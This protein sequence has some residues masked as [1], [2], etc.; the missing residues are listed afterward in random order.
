MRESCIKVVS[1]FVEL[2]NHPSIGVSPSALFLSRRIRTRL[3]LLHP[4]I[5]KTVHEKQA[6]QQKYHVAHCKAIFF[7]VGQSAWAR[8]Y[9]GREKW[10]YGRV[11]E[12]T[13]SIFHRLEMANGMV[14]RRHAD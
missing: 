1:V 6:Q 12:R 14:W 8:N 9:Y 13:G 10:C 3:D 7:E 5:E 2:S 4:S 11:L